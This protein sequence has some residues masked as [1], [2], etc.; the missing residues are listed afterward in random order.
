MSTDPESREEAIK[1]LTESASAM[2]AR[3]ARQISHEAAGQAAAGQA[4]RIIAD[5][6]GGVFVGL[7][8]GFIVD[9]FAGTGPWG[10][11]GG[12]LLGFAVSVF[13]AWRTA[14]RLMAQAKASGVEP[15]SVP[16]D[17]DEED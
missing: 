3:N 2:E 9:R 5:L 14:Q 6:F 8:L 17:D 1:R 15:T 16:F 10:L 7:A 11:I 13:M 12:V 4:W